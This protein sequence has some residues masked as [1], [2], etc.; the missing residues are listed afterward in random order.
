MSRQTVLLGLEVIKL[1]DYD[2]GSPWRMTVD[3]WD[4][5]TGKIHRYQVTGHYN[6]WPTGPPE[7]TLEDLAK[8]Q[9][10]FNRRDAIASELDRLDREAAAKIEPIMQELFRAQAAVLHGPEI[11]D[12]LDRHE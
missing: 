6:G 12:V 2:D 9:A 10:S 1:G 5:K 11:L 8:V 7:R 3:A 4:G